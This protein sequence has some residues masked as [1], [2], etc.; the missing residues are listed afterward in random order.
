[1]D[2]NNEIKEFKAYNF[3]ADPRFQELTHAEDFVSYFIGVKQDI[4]IQLDGVEC[5]I[6]N[7]KLNIASSEAKEL[8]TTDFKELYGKD[9]ESIRKS[10]LQKVNYELYGQ[11]EGYRYQRKV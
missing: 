11:L 3:M 10:H 9:N 2:T 7:A 4:L 8:L 6:A 1:M 5:G